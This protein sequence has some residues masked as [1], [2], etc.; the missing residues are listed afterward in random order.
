MLEPAKTIAE[1]RLASGSG[2]DV[3]ANE[4]CPPVRSNKKGNFMKNRLVTGFAPVLLL[5]ANGCTIVT[6]TRAELTKAPPTAPSS[7]TGLPKAEA[8]YG[9]NKIPYFLP[10]GRLRLQLSVNE[11]TLECEIKVTEVY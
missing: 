1:K 9:R 7:L 3:R 10:T 8:E 6:S 5:L 4:V 2:D 11:K